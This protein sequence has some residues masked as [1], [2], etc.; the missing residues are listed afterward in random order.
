MGI[1]DDAIREHLELKRAPGASDDEVR[2]KEAEAFGAIRQDAPAEPAYEQHTELMQHEDVPILDES[3]APV[4][5]APVEPVSPVP[6]DAVIEDP[7]EPAPEDP[8]AVHAGDSL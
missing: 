7:L 3:L 5:E 8:Y 4:T 1:L 6:V 2:R